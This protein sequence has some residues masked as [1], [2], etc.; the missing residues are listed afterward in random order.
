MSVDCGKSSSVF[1][2]YQVL[3]DPEHAFDLRR[4]FML[5]GLVHLAEP[6]RCERQ[7]LA[8]RLVYRAFDQGDVYLA[9]DV[10]F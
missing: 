6:E 4:Y 1:D 9:H 3:H 10:I 7:F 8:L 2:F 5:D